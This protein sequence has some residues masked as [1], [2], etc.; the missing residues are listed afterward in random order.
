MVDCIATR[1]WTAGP[2]SKVLDVSVEC[3]MPSKTETPFTQRM[4]QICEEA[5]N[6]CNGYCPTRFRAM[7]EECG[8]DFLFSAKKM[9]LSGVIHQ[10]LLTLAKCDALDISMEAVVQ[11]EPWRKDF[12]AEHLEAAAWRMKEAQ[13]RASCGEPADQ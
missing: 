7:V 10:G 1:S 11:Q 9:L 2:L 4:R 3:Q 12:S 8:G 6:R 13:R 5:P